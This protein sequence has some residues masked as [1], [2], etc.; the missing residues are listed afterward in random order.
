MSW[1]YGHITYTSPHILPGCCSP[2]LQTENR[3]IEAKIK[4]ERGSLSGQGAEMGS[5][6]E[7]YKAKSYPDS[8]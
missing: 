4:N 5:E 3:E 6:L 1:D 2:C 7:F 8:S